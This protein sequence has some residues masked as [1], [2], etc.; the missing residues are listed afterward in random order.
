M[1]DIFFGIGR[2]C[3]DSSKD[4]TVL[5]KWVD[6][7]ALDSMGFCAVWIYYDEKSTFTHTLIITKN[8]VFVNVGRVLRNGN[9][10]SWASPL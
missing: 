10:P 3:L 5:V 2:K 6:Y 8:S 9:A 1:G 4:I 7:F